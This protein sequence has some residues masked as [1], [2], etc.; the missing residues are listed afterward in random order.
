MFSVAKSPIILFLLNCTA[1]FIAGTVPTKG[2]EKR[3]RRISSAVTEIVLQAMIIIFG[4]KCSRS[5][6]T[7]AVI[8]STIFSFD[9]FP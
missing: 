4:S 6:S 2:S 8:A 7:K 9:F 3:E 1:C 5:L